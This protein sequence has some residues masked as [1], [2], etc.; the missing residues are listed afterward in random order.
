M[1]GTGYCT[2]LCTLDLKEDLRVVFTWA[3]EW[4][5]SSLKGNI[6]KGARSV[7][8]FTVSWVSRGENISRLWGAQN[9]VLRTLEATLVPQWLVGGGYSRGLGVWELVC[10]CVC[11][12]VCDWKRERLV[13]HLQTCS[14]SPELSVLMTQ[15]R[16]ISA[17]K[18]GVLRDKLL[19]MALPPASDS[20]FSNGITAR[21]SS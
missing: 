14:S 15:V 6:R 17:L 11:F 16:V 7:L 1:A 5:L 13:T 18:M 8:K 20:V 4:S 9:L 12:C 19:M 21:P 2:I 3:T 10:V